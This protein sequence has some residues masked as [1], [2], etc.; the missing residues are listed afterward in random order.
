MTV[1]AVAMG[2]IL[3]SADPTLSDRMHSVRASISRPGNIRVTCSTFNNHT[4]M[5][6]DLLGQDIVVAVHRR[7][8]RMC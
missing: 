4:L 8:N 1:L 3:M 6:L 5:S 7:P 2:D